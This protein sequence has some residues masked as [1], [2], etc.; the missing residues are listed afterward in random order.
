MVLNALHGDPLPVYGD[1]MQVRNWI[2]VEDFA[3]RRSAHVLEHGEPGEVYNVGGPDECAEPRGRPADHRAA[4]AR[5]ESLIEYVT[6]RPGHDRRYSLASEKVRAL[7]WEPQ[8]RFDEGLERDRR[9]VPRQRLVVGA[10]PLGRLPRVL[11]APVRA[12]ARLGAL[13]ARG[14]C[15]KAVHLSSTRRAGDLRGRGVAGDDDVGDLRASQVV[16]SRRVSVGASLRRRQ[17]L[18]VAFSLLAERGARAR[19][20]RSPTACAACASDCRSLDRLRDAPCSAPLNVAA[21]SA[22][23]RS[24]PARRRAATELH[25]TGDR[26]AWASQRIVTPTTSTADGA[27]PRPSRPAA[28]GPA[29]QQ[30]ERLF[31]AAAAVFARTGYADASAEAISREAGMSKATFYEHFANKEECILAL[32]DAAPPRSCSSAI[33]RRARPRPRRA[34]RPRACARACARSST[35]L[36]EYPD[37]AQT[38][39]VEIIGAGPRAMRAPRRD[40]SRLRAGASYARTRRTREDGRV[41]R[42]ASP[43][44]RLRDRRRDRRA[45]LAPAAHRASP[46]DIARARAGDRAPDRS[47]CSAQPAARE[48]APRRSPRSRREIVALPRAARGWSSGASRS[49]ARSA[50][51]SRDE[52]VLG[53]PVPGF[54]DPAARVLRRSA[55][56]PPRTAPTA[57]AACS[58]ATARATGCSRRCTA[59][60]FANQPTSVHARRRPAAARRLRHRRGPLRAARQQADCRRSATTACRTW[61]A[62]SS[63]CATLRVIVCLG[64]LRL[65]R[66]RCARRAALGEPVPRPRP[67]FGHGA[68]LPRPARWTLLGCFHPSQ[69][70]TFTGRL[71]EPMIDAVFARARELAGLGAP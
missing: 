37:E 22:P 42:F 5:D 50:P 14:T 62:S 11:R 28:R 34:T 2:Y 39:L 29:G 9:L 36:D 15:A 24:R 71:T 45:R 44:R 55:S 65:G 56:R 33:A 25:S 8:V 68:E 31:E 12:R 52:D 46:S 66:R 23:A 30:R 13:R 1:G 53:P 35:S 47:A 20:R 61:S 21:R 69:Q 57:P 32:F 3:P 48:R 10:D 19:R 43:R 17:S 16:G 54:G 63:C 27:A 60:G 49:R 26:C 51:R 38:L 18:H 59:P 41:P 6:D 64:A 7:G 58:P 40:R 4:P 70:N 67:R